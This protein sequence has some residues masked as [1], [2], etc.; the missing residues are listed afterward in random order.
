MLHNPVTFSQ[1]LLHQAKTQGLAKNLPW[2]PQFWFI[3]A[4][5]SYPKLPSFPVVAP[6]Q[7]SHHYSAFNLY[8]RPLTLSE[9]ETSHPVLASTPDSKDPLFSGA[10][11]GLPGRLGCESQGPGSEVPT[12]RFLS[13]TCS[14]RLLS[15]RENEE[16][17]DASESMHTGRSAWRCRTSTRTSCAPSIAKARYLLSSLKD[18]NP[19]QGAGPWMSGTVCRTRFGGVPVIFHTISLER[20]MQ[21]L[22]ETW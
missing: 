1:F 13:R 11:L 19:G 8:P 12:D 18:P 5:R 15:E 14:T 16:P 17:L 21:L 3:L 22:C 4:K 6:K 20:T 7:V 2:R 9:L 10:G